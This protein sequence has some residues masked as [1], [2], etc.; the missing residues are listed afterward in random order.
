MIP[1]DLHAAKRPLWVSVELGLFRPSS[2]TLNNELI[3]LL[4]QILSDL[5]A[6]AG[7]MGLKTRSSPLGKINT[8]FSLAA[9]IEM[10]LWNQFSL[11]GGIGYWKKSVSASVE[12]WGELDNFFYRLEDVT[13]VSVRLIPIRVSV[14]GEKKWGRWQYF[15]GLGLTWALSQFEYTSR[16]QFLELSGSFEEDYFRE[17]ARGRAFLPHGE[18]GANYTWEE[19]IRFG[20]IIRFPIGK[21]NHLKIIDSSDPQNLGQQAVFI[22]QGG[23]EK[24]LCWELTGFQAG[25][26]LRYLF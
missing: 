13:N 20:I 7:E 9:E 11:V 17:K 10:P 3:P 16:F 12:A 24:S 2:A 23:R 21:I 26:I 4:N 6:E 19:K 8:N 18:A 15:G 14:R 22:D 5:E 25:L 1:P